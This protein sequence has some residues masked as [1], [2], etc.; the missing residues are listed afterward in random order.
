M[1]HSRFPSEHPEANGF[2]PENYAGAIP[3]TPKEYCLLCYLFQ[4]ANKSLSREQILLHVWGYPHS[5][6]TRTV[7]VH[8][9]HLRKKLSPRVNIQTVFNF[10]YRF[11]TESPPQRESAL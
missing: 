1:S 9:Q 5:T 2:T 4:N 8:I 7:D 10:G 6:H 3:L 11:V